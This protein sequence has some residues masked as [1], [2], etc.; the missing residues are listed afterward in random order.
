MPNRMYAYDCCHAGKMRCGRPTCFTCGARGRY[1]GWAMS[2]HEAQSAFSRATGLPPYGPARESPG[3]QAII[4]RLVAC[5]LCDRTG[6]VQDR[7]NDTW[8]WCPACG[9]NRSAIDGRFRPDAKGST[10][11][12][13]ERNPAPQGTGGHETVPELPRAVVLGWGR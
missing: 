1:V 4:A 6:L 7:A 8:A 9:G 13:D 3:G 10:E 11:R 5:K 12:S 2:M